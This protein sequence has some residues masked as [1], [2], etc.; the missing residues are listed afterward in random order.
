MT[1][2][3]DLE[4][5]CR[6]LLCP[7]PVIELARHLDQVRVG[8]VVAVVARDPAARVDVP[9]WCRMR[10]QEYLGSDLTDQQVPRYLVR[11]T[12]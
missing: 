5:D 3:P 8:Q 6:D 12:G 11:R 7:M 10:G 1:V 4:L 9:A 2:S